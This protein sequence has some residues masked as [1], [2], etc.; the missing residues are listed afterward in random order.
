[1]SSTTSQEIERLVLFGVMNNSEIKVLRSFK[2]F[3]RIK[4]SKHFAN[5]IN[6][7]IFAL[8]IELEKI[9]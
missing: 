1:M 6:I 7:C 9:T 2:K 5:Q 8:S 3:N 4:N